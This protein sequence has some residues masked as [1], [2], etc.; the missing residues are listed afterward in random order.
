MI[1]EVFI[2]HKILSVEIILNTHSQAPQHT[3]ILAI[4]SLKWA[5]NRD[6]TDEDSSTEWK[7]W[8]VYS[9]GKITSGYTWMSPERDLFLTHLPLTPV[10]PVQYMQVQRYHQ[11]QQ[12][13]TSF[14]DFSSGVLLCHERYWSWK[15][16]WPGILKHF[17]VAPAFW[18]EVTGC[19]SPVIRAQCFLFCLST[20]ELLCT[21]WM[22]APDFL[23]LVLPQTISR[24]L[25]RV[26]GGLQSPVFQTF[27]SFTCHCAT[28]GSTPKFSLLAPHYQMY[29]IV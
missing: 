3:S 13:R 7:A 22:I 23:F 1:T 24:Q 10:H 21:L 16:S 12:L 27:E 2:K 28:C 17:A 25:H 9:F 18:L 14:G 15:Y 4:Q 19:Q 26:C 8:Q 11:L 6:E 20:A 29:K 5:A